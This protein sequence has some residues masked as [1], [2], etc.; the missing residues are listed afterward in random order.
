MSDDGQNHID[1]YS[2]N[3]TAMWVS[4]REL[5]NP[6]FVYKV[7]QKFSQL[8]LRPERCL[9]FLADFCCRWPGRFIKDGH[10]RCPS[11]EIFEPS[12]EIIFA[13]GNALQRHLECMRCWW[14]DYMLTEPRTGICVRLRKESRERF[15]IVATIL[16]AMYP[17]EALLWGTHAANDNRPKN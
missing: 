4:D 9:D 6:I 13:D 5:E 17:G 8:E 10:E 7:R 3:L 16:R 15:R 1:R 11:F 14:R 2:P 12:E